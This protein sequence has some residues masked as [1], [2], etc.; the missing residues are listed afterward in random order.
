[1]NHPL[2]R[3]QTDRLGAVPLAAVLLAAG[4]VPD[5]RDKARWRTAAA[6]ISV[7]GCKFFDWNRGCGGGGAI[8]LVIHLYGLN[9]TD[10]LAWLHSHFAH[11]HPTPQPRR[12]STP[13]LKM[14]LCHPRNLPAVRRYLTSQRRIPAALVERLI[15]S[16]S[17]YADHRANA[18]FPLLGNKNAPVGAELR[19]TGARRWRGM[20]PGSDKNLG[21][22]S[23]GN[24][25]AHAVILCE[26]AIDAISCIVLHPRH[27]CISTAGARSHP[28][29]LPDIIRHSLP[30][31]CGFDAD[32][33]G[34]NM[35]A[36]M[37]A[38]YPSLY[39]LRPPQHD[40]NAVLASRS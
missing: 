33:T 36:A 4:A 39:R 35:A 34:D 12:T 37:I 32:A 5:P 11:Q 6:T 30:V 3:E 31:Y 15:S 19:G 21:F 29:W 38:R 1:M 16:G 9:F 18:V 22:F 24:I 8:D 10:A 2:L 20:A 27:W 40:W 7:S 17:L 28:G 25:P 26:S 14:P 13:S 23:V